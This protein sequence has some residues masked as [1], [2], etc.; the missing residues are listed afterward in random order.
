[1]KRLSYI[2]LYSLLTSLLVAP[3]RGDYIELLGLGGFPLSM[4]AGVSLLF[5]MTVFFLKK[6]KD[7]LSPVKILIAM[8]AGVSVLEIPA[9]LVFPQGTIVSLPDYSFKL[10]AVMCGFAFYMARR[11]VCKATITVFMLSSCLWMSYYGY[12]LWL[13]K[14]NYGTFS[15]RVD[16]TA[17]IPLNLYDRDSARVDVSQSGRY[18]VLDFWNSTCGHC[19]KAFPKV[20]ALYD[21]YAGRADVYTVFCARRGETLAAGVEI[22]DGMDYTFGKLYTDFSDPAVRAIGVEGFPTVVILAPDGE[23]VFIGKIELAAGYMEKVV[24]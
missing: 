3:L 24:R 10:S 15:G 9:R 17:V 18:V 22:M 4:L 11:A 14:V 19:F 20:Q 8:S 16:K 5:P 1:M 6:H 12:D 7:E 21:E 2:F 23:K 13:N